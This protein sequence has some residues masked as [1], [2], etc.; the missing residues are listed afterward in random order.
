ME[1]VFVC[2]NTNKDFKSSDFEIRDNR[3]VKTDASGNKVLDAKV[4]LTVPC[5]F[6]GEKHVYQVSELACP[7]NG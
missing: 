1:F 6:C 4:A 3:G 7:F 5:P 2:R